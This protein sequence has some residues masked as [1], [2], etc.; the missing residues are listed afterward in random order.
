MTLP[1]QLPKRTLPLSPRASYFGAILLTA[2]SR[3]TPRGRIESLD[4]IRDQALTDDSLEAQ[5]LALVLQA[6]D[7]WK[8][9]VARGQIP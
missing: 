7:H 3:D 4:V 2:N 9:A 1:L 5:D 8:L 6:Y